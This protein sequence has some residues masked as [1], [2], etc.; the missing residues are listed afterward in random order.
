MTR[1][2]EMP[3]TE[4][5][6][7]QDPGT[8]I[9]SV[10]TKGDLA[11]LSPQER[12]QYY[13]EVC[14]S[15]GLNPFTRPF[16][17]II[18]NGKL[19]LYA[20][21]DAADQLRKINGI[22]IEVVSRKLEDELVVVHVRASDKTGRTDE[23]FG[24]VT[25]AH[26]TGEARAN[27]ILKAITKAKR[28]VTLSISGLGF[29]DE[30]EVDDMPVTNRVP[31]PI[32]AAAELDA[33]AAAPEPTP[34][35]QEDV[36]GLPPIGRSQLFTQS[37][38]RIEPEKLLDGTAGWN[39]WAK[40]MLYVIAQVATDAELDKLSI[41]NKDLLA[42]LRRSEHEDG[43]RKILDAAATRRAELKQDAGKAA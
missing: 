8:L 32:S 23:D 20:R 31:T 2:T 27:A 15:V 17:Y 36:F 28:R 29:I 21:R 4:V 37:S 33:F 35:P 26:L 30:T 41:D 42:M 25:I 3:Q 5:A 38:Y 43:Y 11:K 19:I 13:V 22:S 16:E 1:K 40:D 12:T 10:V 7:S 18:L 9:E 34:Q 6:P 39:Q 24:A 14:R